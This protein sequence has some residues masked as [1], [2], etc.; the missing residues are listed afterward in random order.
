VDSGYNH[1]E[2]ANKPMYTIEENIRHVQKQIAKCAEACGRTFDSVTLI[3]ISKTFPAEIVTEAISAGLMRFGENRIQEAEPKI[4]HLR[5]SYKIEWHMVGH[6]QSNK[7]KRA[8][9]LFDVIHS[10]D[11]L[12]LAVKLNES[13]EDLG[14][15]LSVLLQVD[16]GEEETKFGVSRGQVREIVSAIASMKWIKLD[17]LMTIPPFFDDPE[18]T[19]PYFSELRELRFSLDQEQPGCLGEKHLS[20]GMSNDFQVAIQEGST[21]VRIGTA[22]FGTRNRE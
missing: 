9:E 7:T 16:L 10:V 17:G 2:A 21:M 5:N 6:L 14:K 19:R 4:M 11:S 12:K 15:T 13:C 20:M 18:L 8:A 3:A 22:L 1:R